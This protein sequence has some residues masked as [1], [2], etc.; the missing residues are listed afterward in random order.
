MRIHYTIQRGKY[1]YAYVAASA[2]IATGLSTE[3][4]K[5]DK[6]RQRFKGSDV[7]TSK[8]NMLLDKWSSDFA[9]WWIDTSL[10]GGDTT[11][12]ACEAYLRKV[13][14]AEVEVKKTKETAQFVAF[15]R[16]HIAKI[17]AEAR[18]IYKSYQQVC[19]RFERVYGP[20]LI[21]DV[22]L[23]HIE[24]YIESCKQ[25]GL[26][27]T[28]TQTH[29]KRIRAVLK[30]AQDAGHTINQT[31]L[32]SGL[33]KASVRDN[34]YLNTA[35]LD[36]LLQLPTHKLTPGQAA[37]RDLFLI[38]AHTGL[39]LGDYSV[40]S[41]QSIIDTSYGKGIRVETKKV[42]KLIEVPLNAAVRSIIDQY[43]GLMPRL[44]DAKLNKGIKEVCAIAGLTHTVVLYR[45]IAGKRQPESK[46]LCD[47]VCSHTARRSFATNAYLAGVPMLAIMKITGHTNSKTFLNYI[48]VSES[49]NAKNVAGHD[50]FK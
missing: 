7:Q 22:S 45:D 30:R 50:F 26:N 33:V 5:W 20:V 13:L 23:R 4:A 40:L 16:A 48:K 39:R 3:A 32:V 14:K 34:V 49:E 19:N 43:Q 12:A 36:L 8:I 6:A 17:K 1:L 15:F 37:A 46:R 24:G 9:T 10:A 29:L 41:K 38:G 47:A 44:S 35:Q 2:K 18:Q 21:K 28:T 31:A 11:V 27:P 25:G 42:G